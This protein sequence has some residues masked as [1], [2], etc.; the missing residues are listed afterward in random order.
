[1][2]Q[3]ENFGKYCVEQRENYP[4]ACVL[5]RKYHHVV[6]VFRGTWNECV[7]W[8]TRKSVKERDR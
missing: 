4:Y 6:V 3:S 5:M 8:A 1:M 7:E 2:Y